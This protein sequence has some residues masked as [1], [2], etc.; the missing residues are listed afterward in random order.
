MLYFCCSISFFKIFFKELI[1]VCISFDVAD[2]CICCIDTLSTLHL[3]S[4]FTSFFRLPDGEFSIHGFHES[5]W[6]NDL[7]LKLLNNCTSKIFFSITMIEL[8]YSKQE[9]SFLNFLE[10]Q[11]QACQVVEITFCFRIK[12]PEFHLRHPKGLHACPEWSLR[13]QRISSQ[14]LLMCLSVKVNIR[15]SWWHFDTISVSS[16]EFCIWITYA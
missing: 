2:I 4:W 14:E 3:T 10:L 11:C 13:V 12:T 5:A 9:V 6:H 7:N 1:S 8:F 16:F 15:I